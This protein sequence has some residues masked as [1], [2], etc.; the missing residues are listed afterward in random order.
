MLDEFILPRLHIRRLGDR[1]Y[2]ILDI[3]DYLS[4]EYLQHLSHW[5]IAVVH[6]QD[7]LL[8][9]VSRNDQQTKPRDIKIRGS[10]T[11]WYLQKLEAMQGTKF[12]T[13]LLH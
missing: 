3:F 6:A 13:H 11:R 5:L 8:V 10:G 2:D 1:K 7:F 9:T 4:G 12:P